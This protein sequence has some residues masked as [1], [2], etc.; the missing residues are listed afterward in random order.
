MGLPSRQ[1]T[2]IQRLLLLAVFVAIGIY[3]ADNLD[4][5][6]TIPGRF[7]WPYIFY[8]LILTLLG[9]LAGYSIWRRIAAC[10]DMKTSWWHTGK[11]WFLSRL[12]RYIPGKV[13]LLLIRFSAYQGHSRTKVSAATL[14]EAYT[15]IFAVTLLMLLFVATNANAAAPPLATAIAMAVALF[16]LSHPAVLRSALR[17]TAKFLPIPELHSLPRQRDTL[18]FV[19]FQLISMLLHGGALFMVFNAVGDVAP[20]HYLLITAAFFIAGLI[21]ML[22]VFAPSGI[23]VREAALIVLLAKLVEPAT[24]IAGIIIIRLIGIVSELLLAGFF[25]GYTALRARGPQQG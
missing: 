13:P 5:L 14:L 8:G 25:A 1:G 16:C 24:L 22:A 11:A 7:D 12:G 23:G 17:L 6:Q 10:F 4:R 9:H 2:I 19:G 3:V 20:V 15:S 21:G 18:G